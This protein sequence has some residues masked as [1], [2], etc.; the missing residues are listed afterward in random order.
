MSSPL[1]APKKASAKQ[2]MLTRPLPVVSRLSIIKDKTKGRP[3]HPA[4]KTHPNK[5]PPGISRRLKQR[6]T[7]RKKLFLLTGGFLDHR[8]ASRI[9]HSSSVMCLGGWLAF[10]SGIST[11]FPSPLFIISSI[12][13]GVG[14]ITLPLSSRCSG[15][16]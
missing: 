6:K 15:T 13:D 3:I 8:Q 9:S 1:P 2:A 11:Y 12:S 7:A 4:T 5:K 16:S 10:S 14:I